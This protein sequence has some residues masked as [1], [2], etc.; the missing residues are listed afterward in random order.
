MATKTNNRTT[1]Q[2][3]SS[4]TDK[5]AKKAYDLYLKSGCVSG[6]DM[7]NWLAAERQIKRSTR[8]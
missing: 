6:R 7:D 8:S 3:S 1:T 2:T 5:I 4:L